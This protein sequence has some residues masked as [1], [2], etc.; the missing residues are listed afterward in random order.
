MARERVTW[1]ELGCPRKTGLYRFG[2]AAIRVKNIHILVAEDDPAALFTVVALRPPM[3][4][5]EYH[6]GHRI[7]A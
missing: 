5:P 6:L 2:G 7:S 4:P 1:G 3:G